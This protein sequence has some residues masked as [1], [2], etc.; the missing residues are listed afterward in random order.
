MDESMEN[1]AA[2]DNPFDSSRRDNTPLEHSCGN[3]PAT[4]QVAAPSRSL[5]LLA[6]TSEWFVGVGPTRLLMGFVALRGWTRLLIRWLRLA[7]APAN[8]SKPRLHRLAR[9][10]WFQKDDRRRL[11]HAR[12]ANRRHFHS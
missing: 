2:G 4:S 9:A 10:A 8:R 3:H 12:D 11:P 5:T 1:V 7:R 6:R